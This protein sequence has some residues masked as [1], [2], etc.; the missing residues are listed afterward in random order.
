MGLIYL[1]DFH[2]LY[3]L[4]LVFVENCIHNGKQLDYFVYPGHDHNVAGPDRAHLI[5]KIT[6][7]FKDNL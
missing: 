6:Q 3:R 2:Q 7:Y 4:V 5:A 1:A